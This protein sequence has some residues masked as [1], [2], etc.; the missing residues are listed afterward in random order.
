MP[1]QVR[2]ENT[3]LGASL[4]CTATSMVQQHSYGQWDFV[5]GPKRQHMYIQTFKKLTLK[6][7]Q[8]NI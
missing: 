6:G 7:D 5:A 4:V 3:I 8:D 1:D 2:L